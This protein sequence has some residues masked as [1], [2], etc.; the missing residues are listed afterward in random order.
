MY[1]HFTSVKCVQYNFNL[2]ILNT[3]TCINYQLNVPQKNVGFLFYNSWFFYVSQSLMIR[4]YIFIFFN[5][6]HICPIWKQ[7]C[8]DIS[9]SISVIFWFPFI[10][11]KKMI[12]HLIFC[13]HGQNNVL[14][15]NL[16]HS[17]CNYSVVLKEYS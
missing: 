13:L 16:F 15:N 1:D 2:G 11:I 17:V 12:L 5:V 8:E 14:S 10:L 7:P 6:V 3:L 4:S 9:P